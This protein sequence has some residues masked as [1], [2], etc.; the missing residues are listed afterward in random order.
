M[1]G[2]T[3]AKFVHGPGWLIVS[4]Q[5]SHSFR[6]LES[7]TPHVLSVHSP[8]RGRWNRTELISVFASWGHSFHTGPLAATRMRTV[9][10]FS[11]RIGSKSGCSLLRNP[12]SI[13]NR[14][15]SSLVRND[16]LLAVDL[17]GGNSR[18]QVMKKIFIIL[19]KL[20][21]QH[22]CRFGFL[23]FGFGFDWL[24]RTATTS[25]TQFLIHLRLVLQARTLYLMPTQKRHFALF[26]DGISTNQEQSA[27]RQES[28]QVQFQVRSCVTL[29]TVRCLPRRR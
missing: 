14:K 24:S 20:S 10:L 25:H 16:V 5:G 19:M 2:L 6:V 7:Q 1:E 9:I 8:L 28:V 29:I 11:F 23:G 4:S 13:C 21:A 26:R 12:I 17:I 22:F 15:L 27:I 18:Y 3:L